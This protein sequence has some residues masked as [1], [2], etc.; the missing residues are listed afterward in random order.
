MTDLA[1]RTFAVLMAGGA[2]TRFWPLSRRSR[3]KQVL[4]LVAGEPLV[5]DTLRRLEGL[6]PPDRT[7]VVTGA[8]QAGALREALPE[9]PAGN[10][11][12]EP[13]PRN[14]AA[15]LG[16]AAVETRRSDPDAVLLCLPADGVVRPPGAFR[17]PA[18]RALARADEAGS[19]LTF[20]VSPVRPATG[21]GYVLAGAEVGP[22]VRRVEEFVEKPDRETAERYLADGRYRWNSGMFA[23]RADALLGELAVHLPELAA[24]LSRIAADPGLL[25]EVFPALPAISVD[26]GVL[27]RTARAEVVETAFEW[28]DLGSYEA[29]ARLLPAD[30]AG[31]RA[32]ADLLA[33]DSGGVLAFAPEGH[34]VATL[35]VRDLVVVSDRDVTLV[36]PRERAEEVRRIVEELHRTGRGDR[37]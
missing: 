9:L 36:V 7:L 3:P 34:L 21:Y 33:L 8:D 32:S 22:G 15:C 1:G 29:L 30:A 17:E 18:R 37:A 35:G 26:Y 31:N 20:G 2:G 13:A 23:W 4:P 25:G 11:L 19:L 10:F 16:W 6:V 27:E 12:L 14:T 28:D 24:G 5:G